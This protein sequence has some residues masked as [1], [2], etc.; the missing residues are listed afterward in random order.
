MVTKGERWLFKSRALLGRKCLTG[1]IRSF[2]NYGIMNMVMDGE[3]ETENHSKILEK[4]QTLIV[5]R[6]SG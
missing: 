3:E 2:H 6:S 4:Q 5:N 1:N